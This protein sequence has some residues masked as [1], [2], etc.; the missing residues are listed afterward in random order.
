MDLGIKDRVAMVAAA[1]KGVGKACAVALAQE[2][3]KVSIC[4]R[5]AEELEKTRSEIEAGGEAL[6]VVADVSSASDLEA[7]Y[8]RTIDRFGRVDILVTNTGGPPVKRFIELS[9][10]SWRLKSRCDG[11]ASRASLARSWPSWPRSV[12]AI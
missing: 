8:R 7:W 10:E 4:A 11:S 2:G 12:R 5:N 1:S 9:D 6:A 3:C